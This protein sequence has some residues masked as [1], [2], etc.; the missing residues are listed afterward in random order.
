MSEPMT[1][2][3]QD[4]I[5]DYINQHRS[6]TFGEL[7]QV[8]TD[9]G[10]QVDGDLELGCGDG[11]LWGCLSREFAEAVWNLIDQEKVRVVPTTQLDLLVSSPRVMV[12]KQPPVPCRLEAL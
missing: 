7:K 5:L 8:G 2:T 1:M 6:V 4:F 10:Y 9:A 3:L 11:Y 12:S